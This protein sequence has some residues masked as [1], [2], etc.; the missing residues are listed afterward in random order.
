MGL[1]KQAKT[2]TKGQVDAVLGY[3]AKTRWPCQDPLA[4]Q[5]QG[6]LPPVGQGRPEGQGDSLPDLEDDHRRP[7]PCRAGN[8]LGR[9]SEQGPVRPSNPHERGAKDRTS[10]VCRNGLDADQHLLDPEREVEGD[11]AASRRQLVLAL[12]PARRF[13]RLFESLRASNF[14]NQ[15]REED[16]D[17]RGIAPG[18]AD[19]GRP[20]QPSDHPSLYRGQRGGAG[21]DRGFGLGATLEDEFYSVKTVSF[22]AYCR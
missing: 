18:R 20:L 10:R 16:I 15:Y 2:L 6:H 21:P 8:P 9:H 19:A 17:R 3:L 7:G 14:Y 4:H 12:V 5:E 13:R 1:G 11:V 22:L